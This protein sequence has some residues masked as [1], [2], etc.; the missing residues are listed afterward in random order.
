VAKVASVRRLARLRRHYR[1]F[2]SRFYRRHNRLHPV[3]RGPLGYLHFRVMGEARGLDPSPLF[4]TD[5]VQRQRGLAGQP[6]L[7]RPFTRYLDEPELWPALD[8]HPA[9]FS[10][11]DPFASRAPTACP[12]E[13]LP[14]SQVSWLDVDHP[15]VPRTIRERPVGSPVGIWPDGS[16]GAGLQ[17]LAEDMGRATAMAHRIPVDLD[18]LMMAGDRHCPACAQYRVHNVVHALRAEGLRA[19]ALYADDIPRL[20]AFDISTRV[21]VMSR[22]LWRPDVAAFVAG[23]R[24]RGARIGFECDDILFDLPHVLGIQF[25]EA[26]RLAT[27]DVNYHSELCTAIL[28]DADFGIFPTSLLANVAQQ[29][30][31]AL[32]DVAIAPSFLSSH[33]LAR[34]GSISPKT[35][36]ARVVIAYS[37][38][39]WTHS[40]D[41]Q[42]IVAPLAKVLGAQRNAVLRVN[43]SL[44]VSKYREL[45]PFIEDGRVIC[46]PRVLRDWG[47]HLERLAEADVNIV[48]LEMDNGFCHAKSEVR[49]IESGSVG[50]PTVASPTEAYRRAIDHGVTGMLAGD[51]GAWVRSLLALVDDP[52]AREAMGRAARDDVRERYSAEG[53]FA[54]C[55]IEAL[56]QQI[57]HETAIPEAR[58]AVPAPIAVSSAR[59]AGIVMPGAGSA[60]EWRDGDGRCL[61]A[62]VPSE[63]DGPDA[64]A[65]QILILRTRADVALS[66]EIGALS[67]P[68]PIAALGPALRAAVEAD[69]P[70]ALM[71]LPAHDPDVFFPRATEEPSGAV[72]VDV[73]ADASVAAFGSDAALALT[74]LSQAVGD[75]LDARE[76]VLVCPG[77][78]HVLPRGTPAV[79]G[80]TSSVE[81]AT[82]MR[83]SPALVV[84]D[85]DVVTPAVGAA[86]LTG[87]P[88]V[89]ARAAGGGVVLEP[90][91]WTDDEALL[92]D[93]RSLAASVFQGQRAA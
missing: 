2:D 46:D 67:W 17:A 90:V 27:W 85:G 51:G 35:R 75:A 80:F 87:T 56:T 12:L 86:L 52:A 23:Q 22:P 73:P 62:R 50:V 61:L 65:G 39:T 31:P 74:A 49:Y 5:F 10:R 40:A 45:R 38:G 84:L 43:G 68:M 15:L 32:G 14:H 26:G 71:G 82:L 4:S 55:M 53:E 37:S 21:L 28:M 77:R 58:A 83:Q 79:G 70:N 33:Q 76:V 3:Y 63:V 57:H 93:F 47:Q 16:L 44:D 30:N 20:E 69:V 81:F 72:L 42:S 54:R 6:F 19:A 7:D 66:R 88:I 25:N 89:T 64:T 1:V 24:A 18:V 8:P 36:D 59:L 9:V 11:G 78:S 48:P 29:R 60:G 91:A 13:Q 34:A 41:F 92:A